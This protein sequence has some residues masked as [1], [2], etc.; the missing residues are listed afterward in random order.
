[1][2]THTALTVPTWFVGVDGI[3]FA[4]RGWGKAG[5]IPLVFLD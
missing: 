5:G 4:Y 2:N 3:R 1:M